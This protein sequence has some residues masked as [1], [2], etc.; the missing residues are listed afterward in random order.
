LVAG[1]LLAGLAVAASRVLRRVEGDSMAPTL[2]HRDVVVVVPA[3][4]D[5]R[6]RGQVVVIRD[7]REPA[8]ETVKRV[9]AL[10]GDPFDAMADPVPPGRICVTGDNPARSTD[11]RSYGPIRSDLLVGR[12]VAR[13]WPSPGRIP[14]S[15]DPGN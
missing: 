15:A 5:E 13:L 1:A 7:P 10:Q 12:V 2:R 14:P 3:R 4:A 9:A 6:L 8:R 11:S